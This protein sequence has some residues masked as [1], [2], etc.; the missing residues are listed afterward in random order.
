MKAIEERFPTPAVPTEPQRPAD[1]RTTA[2]RPWLQ[3]IV[4]SVEPTREVFFLREPPDDNEQVI[5]WLPQTRFL[6]RGAE[7]KSDALRQGQLVS[8]QFAG[9]D[10]QR[11]AKEID[12]AAEPP[13]I[14]STAEL[15][16]SLWPSRSGKNA[17]K[18][19]HS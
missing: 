16:R 9:D 13:A 12:I 15:R 1:A 8:V 19:L 4:R 7:A 5:R 10:G 11:F 17:L 6:Y 18:P 3:G 14:G 2:T